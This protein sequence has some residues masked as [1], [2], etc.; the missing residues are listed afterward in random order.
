MGSRKVIIRVF[1]RHV[2]TRRL[3]KYRAA[4][5]SWLQERAQSVRPGRTGEKGTR[6]DH[7][8]STRQAKESSLDIEAALVRFWPI[9]PE[10]TTGVQLLPVLAA[11]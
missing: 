8:L 10:G 1:T 9:M 3:R 11:G 4:G 6:P 2:P 7:L 5:W